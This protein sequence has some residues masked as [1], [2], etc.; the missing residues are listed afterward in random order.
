MTLEAAKRIDDY[1]LRKIAEYE[2]IENPSDG[3]ILQLQYF[4]DVYQALNQK[5]V[6]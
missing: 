5:E 6:L 2:A 1:Q 3:Q 4:R